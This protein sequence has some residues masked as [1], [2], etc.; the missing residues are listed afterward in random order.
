MQ[1]TSFYRNFD[2]SNM[3]KPDISNIQRAMMV[4]PPYLLFLIGKVYIF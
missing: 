3:E 1:N 2:S 4:C